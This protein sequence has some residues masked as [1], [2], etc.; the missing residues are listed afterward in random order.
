MILL[1][2]QKECVWTPL[3]VD[4]STARRQSNSGSKFQDGR[5][6][7]PDRIWRD[8]QGRFKDCLADLVAPLSLTIAWLTC[9]TVDIVSDERLSNF[10]KEEINWF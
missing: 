5:T 8:S 2:P 4:D 6:N 1:P 7:V 10:T 9:D 3:P